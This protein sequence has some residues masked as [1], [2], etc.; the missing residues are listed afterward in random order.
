MMMM[1]NNQFSKLLKFVKNAHLYISFII[2][3]SRLRLALATAMPTK[4]RPSSVQRFRAS[5]IT[6][7]RRLTTCRLTFHIELACYSWWHG[8]CA[9]VT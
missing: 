3:M 8:G 9:T 4:P 7:G 5:D 2:Y 6:L 1:I